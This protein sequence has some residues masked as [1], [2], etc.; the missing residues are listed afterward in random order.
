KNIIS[1]SN[2]LSNTYSEDN[3]HK[4][5]TRERYLS[6]RNNSGFSLLIF[7][8]NNDV[9]TAK[10][11]EKILSKRIR[12]TD[13]LGWYGT[14]KISALLPETEY[15]DAKI[16]AEFVINGLCYNKNNGFYK[17]ISYPS[18]KWKGSNCVDHYKDVIKEDFSQFSFK[19][20][21]PFWKRSI[22]FFLASLGI[23]LLSPLLLIVALL[24]KIVSKGPIIFTQKR[25]GLKGAVFKFYKFRTM[26]V[27]N[28]TEIHKKYLTELINGDNGTEK[29]MKKL[30]NTCTYPFANILRYSYIDE[31]PQLFN[32]LSGEMSLVGPRPCIP[33]EAEEYLRWHARRFDIKPGMT[34]LWQISGKNEKTF[35]EMILLDL[36]YIS[37]QSLW[38]DIKILFQTPLVILSQLFTHY[39]DS[40]KKGIQIDIDFSAEEAT[41]R[42]TV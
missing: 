11:L 1:V 2:S 6:D 8:V 12:E 9:C 42:V 13:T 3:F 20:K 4:L 5:I 40:Q 31:L 10:Q 27:E 30:E 36:E 24:I 39:K 15:C 25:V 28:D 29:S 34:G 17:I 14:N 18:R 22:D 32:V 21:I 38:L 16:L 35:K 26:N 23:I 33:Y 37:K 7:N 19:S 41:N